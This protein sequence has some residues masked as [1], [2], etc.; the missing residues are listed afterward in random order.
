VSSESSS[1]V[2]RVF[3]N[4]IYF[5]FALCLGVSLSC[6]WH[7]C[8]LF[9]RPNLRSFAPS[10]LLYWD[11]FDTGISQSGSCSFVLILFLLLLLKVEEGFEGLLGKPDLLLLL[12]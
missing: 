4:L 12:K 11:T 10:L 9:F 3:F 1:S 8:F 7:D 5:I 2:L 6:K